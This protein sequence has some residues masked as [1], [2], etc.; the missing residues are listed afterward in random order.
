MGEE[1]IFRI[2]IK[3]I[4]K[5]FTFIVTGI[6]ILDAIDNFIEYMQKNQLPYREKTLSITVTPIKLDGGVHV[7]QV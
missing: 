4:G 7:I 3:N 2:V 1:L 5:N 6:N